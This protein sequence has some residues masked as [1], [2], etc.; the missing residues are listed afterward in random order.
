MWGRGRNPCYGLKHFFFLASAVHC[1]DT[2]EGVH[3]TSIG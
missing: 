1:R 2:G 3:S